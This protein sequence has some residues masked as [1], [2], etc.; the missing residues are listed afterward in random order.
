MEDTICAISTSLSVGAISIIRIS[1]PKAIVIVNSIFSSNLKNVKSHTIKYGHIIYK[2]EIIDEVLV[3]VMKKPR[4]YTM[5]DVVEINLHGGVATTNKVLEILLEI[6]CR[7][8]EPGEFTKRA[9]LNGRI[10]LIESEAVNELINAKTESKRKLC[11][12]QIGGNLTKI[13]NNI[14]E[15]LVKL[16]ANI[17][18]NIDYP[19][20]EDNL[21]ITEN[22]LREQLDI[23]NKEIDNLKNT[24]KFG[25]IISSGINV[26]IIG[27][28]NVGKSSILNHLLD[29]EKAIVTDIAGTT[30]DIVE[31]SIS[32]NGIELKLIDTAGIHET[33]DFVEKIGVN[34]SLEQLENADL[35]ILVLDGSNKLTI[36][37]KKLLKLVGL[38][39]YIIFINKSDLK[40]NIDINVEK[41][42][43]IIYGNTLDV[44]GL[45]NLKNKIIELFELN[46]INKDLT[47]L[48]NARQI[49]LINKASDSIKKAI[50][51]L[52]QNIPI[53]MISI[54]LKNCYDYLGSIIGKTYSD[55]II[56]QLFKDFCVG[57]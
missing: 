26:A 35:L 28:P 25:K 57:K 42:N 33:S 10:D 16:M 6:G 14:R 23:I 1:G 45:D 46:E 11:L 5:E 40:N 12:N 55:D 22:L 53:D 47:Y 41:Y 19:E 48:S 9:F 50:N 36:D 4:T 7:L 17:E 34:K 18:V 20:Y 39:K 32:L 52:T 30:R 3:S 29:E 49:S 54:D 51:A 13:I 43:N 37:D 8:A 15:K 44:N 56:N 21:I 27:K 38:K 31:G 24:S 2:D